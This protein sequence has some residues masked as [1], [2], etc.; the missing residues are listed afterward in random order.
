[1]S[2]S[3]ENHRAFVFTEEGQV[4]LLRAVEAARRAFDTS[5]STG[6]CLGRYLWRAMEFSG[7]SFN[8]IAVIDR[9]VEIGYIFRVGCVGD[10]TLD[11]VFTK[12]AKWR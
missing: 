6:A 7:D 1:M 12:G 5:G 9:L 10:S 8:A 3:Y 11:A 2:Y 4:Y